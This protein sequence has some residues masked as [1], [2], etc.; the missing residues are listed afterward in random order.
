[1]LVNCVHKKFLVIVDAVFTFVF[2]YFFLADAVSVA[3]PRTTMTELTRIEGIVTFTGS[4][5][6]T[7]SF[8]AAGL[9]FLY[10]FYNLAFSIL[11]SDAVEKRVESY[12]R[13]VWGIIAIFILVSIW[14][15]VQ[16]IEAVLF[17][18]GSRAPHF[19][20]PTP[21]TLKLKPGG[22][23]TSN[24]GEVLDPIPSND[25][26]RVN[27]IPSN[28][29]ERSL[30]VE[31]ND[32]E[33]VNNIPSNDGERSLN[34]EPNDGEGSRNIKSNDGEVLSPPETPNI[35]NKQGLP[36]FGR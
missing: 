10:F 29:G 30:N 7:I 5:I 31:P 3:Q 24:D 36:P 11:E 16:F 6:T 35:L 4:L 12:K 18:G 9:A 27:N 25:G 14:G 8:V 26:E 20:I 23:I 15:I 34:V 13:T 1:M 17:G 22:L 2:L 33:R 28:D 32:G 19:V 21:T